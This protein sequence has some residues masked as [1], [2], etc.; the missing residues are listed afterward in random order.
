MIACLPTF[1][2]VIDAAICDSTSRCPITQHASYLQTTKL[3]TIDSAIRSPNYI[4]SKNNAVGVFNYDPYYYW[5]RIII[6]NSQDTSRQLMLLMAP[7]GMFDGRL[8]QTINGKW[9]MV[10]KTGLKYEFGDRSYQFTHHVFPFTLPPKSI[11]TLYV[12]VDASNV[13]KLFGFALIK[14]HDFKIYES[15]IYFVFGIIVGLLLLF[16]VLNVSLFFALKDKK[17]LHLW[18]SFYIALLFLIVMKNDQLDQQFLGM[19]SERAFRYIPYAAVGA[20]A[21][22]ILIHVVQ[23]FLRDPLEKNKWLYRLNIIFK[24]NVLASAV[25]HSFVFLHATNYH[26]QNI[27]FSWLKD[28]ILLCICLIIIDCLYAFKNGFKGALF[29]FFGSFVFMIGSLQRLFFPTSLSFLFPPTTF[30]IGIIMET[31]IISLGL[32]YRYWLEMELSK[33][34]EEQLRQKEKDFGIQLQQSQLEIQEQTFNAISREIHD[35]VGQILSLAKVQLS[36]I[37]QSESF[38]K[39]LVSEAKES[40]SKAM[41]DLRDISKSL[42]S[43][44]IQLSSL[45]EITGQELQRINRS[46]IMLTSLTVDGQEQVVAQQKKLI[47]FRIIQEAFQNILKHSHA[48]NIDVTFNYDTHQLRISITDNGKGFDKE[49]TTNNDGLGLQNIFTRTALIGGTAQINSIINKGT[50]ITIIL[51]YA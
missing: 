28:S 42:N 47:I 34:K 40:V 2:Q 48:K 18:Y 31:F 16:F 41:T 49:L 5:F 1:C 20:Y 25:V 26:I 30:H 8:F 6:K 35:N 15:N 12:S 22:A 17:K 45:V 3:I 10:A 21:I 7:V 4:K 50:I 36:I 39:A 29:L 32:I 13:Y 14:P 43:E 9:K 19:D 38:D 11:D 37:D 27:V 24:I 23:G 51:P 33:Q 46:G 44:R